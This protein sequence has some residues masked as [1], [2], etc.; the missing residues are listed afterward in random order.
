MPIK[1][2]GKILKSNQSA[3]IAALLFMLFLFCISCGVPVKHY[4]SLM[5]AG[6]AGFEYRADYEGAV[7][8]I[9]YTDSDDDMLK[10]DVFRAQAAGPLPVFVFIHGGYW[11]SGH[12]KYYASFAK[13][14]NP[15]GFTVV[16]VDYRLYPDVTYPEFV[17]DCVKAL[18]WTAENIAEYG[19][20]PKR[21]YVAGSSA[22]SHI[23]AM[24][25][26]DDQFR[27]KLRFDPMKV[28]GVLLT[29]GA[30]DFDKDNLLDEEILREVLGPQENY[31]KAQPIKYLRADIPPMLIVNGDR[32]PLTSEAQASRF[33]GELKETGA[34]VEYLVIP[35]GDH[36]SVGLGM[37]AGN[38]D[39]VF[40][41][42]I[43]FAE[44]T[45]AFS[46]D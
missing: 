41:A 36:H 6:Y 38:E 30:Y 42:F 31:D 11:K 16:L 20:D 39:E 1:H 8:D 12:R 33:A 4:G 44:K 18:N 32:D 25:F 14:L 40:E 7:R 15:E 17:E 46:A 10:L 21:M 37:T 23:A 3:I 27:D 19:G 45:G 2:M 26:L 34:P 28:K 43:R 22:G 35:G 24:I 13:S 9:P 5:S 29:S